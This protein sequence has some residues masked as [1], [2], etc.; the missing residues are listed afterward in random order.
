MDD[1]QRIWTA[2][3]N[4]AQVLSLYVWQT[5]WAYWIIYLLKRLDEMADPSTSAEI[6]GEVYDSIAAR[7]DVGQWEE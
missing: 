5:Y 7:L 2:L 3:N 6:L 1:S 4:A